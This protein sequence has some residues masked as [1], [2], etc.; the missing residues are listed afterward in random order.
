[1]G[2]KH[3]AMI[4]LFS[5]SAA[6]GGTLNDRFPFPDA[7]YYQYPN[8]VLVGQGTEGDRNFEMW[9]GQDLGF[10]PDP[11]SL[12]VWDQD[13]PWPRLFQGIILEDPM[14]VG[15]VWRFLVMDDDPFGRTTGTWTWDVPRGVLNIATV[16][17]PQ[18][19]A[20][21]LLLF[22]CGVWL[23]WHWVMW[24]KERI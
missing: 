14:P 3:V 19:P 9:Y 6:Y 17:V 18:L 23:G 5:V 8:G 2:L 22:G 16:G 1:M 12:E 21:W 11:R 24:N 20:G 15:E 10:H 13:D 7:S 4:T